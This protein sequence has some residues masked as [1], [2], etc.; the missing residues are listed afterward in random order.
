MHEEPAV[1]LLPAGVQVR[2]KAGGLKGAIVAVV[3]AEAAYDVAMS[4]SAK[5]ERVAHAEVEVVQPGKK[6]KLVIISGEHKGS[7]GVLIGID[8]LDGI[9][10][11]Q[12]NGDIKILDLQSCAKLN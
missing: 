2:L 11:M 7:T 12:A 3:E 1:E 8:G 4:D 10:K 5:T 6:E 9:V